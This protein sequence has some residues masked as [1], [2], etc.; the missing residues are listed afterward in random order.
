MIQMGVSQ[1]HDVDAGR[2]EAER[3]AVFLLQ[4]AA[5]LIQTAI[6][7]DALARTFDQMTRAGDGA[8]GAVKRNFQSKLSR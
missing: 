1:K 7:Q 4:L 8:R 5:A 6:D 3:M 2:I